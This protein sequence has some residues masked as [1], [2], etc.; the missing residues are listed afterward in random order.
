MPS[1]YLRSWV[2][3]SKR[4]FTEQYLLQAFLAFNS[5]FE[6][7]FPGSYMHTHYPEL[8]EKSFDGY[9]HKV[10]WPSDFWMKRK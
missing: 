6:I 1:E 5:E 7:I 8:L 3:D 10:N 2:L 4:F 9:D